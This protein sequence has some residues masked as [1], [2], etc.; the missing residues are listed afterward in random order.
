MGLIWPCCFPALTPLY[1][2]LWGFIKDTVYF[3]PLPTDVDLQAGIVDAVAEVMPD[4]LW[5]IGL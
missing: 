1:F 3:P 5:S 2:F 4:M